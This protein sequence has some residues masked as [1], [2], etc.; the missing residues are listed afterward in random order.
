M[1][2]PV[3]MQFSDDLVKTTSMAFLYPS[4]QSGQVGQDGE[5]VVQ[6]KESRKYVSIGVRGSDSEK[7]LRKNLDIID[8]WLAVNPQ[9]TVDGEPRYLG[10]NSP[11]I[12]SFWK[13]N[14][15]QV[16][17]VETANL[18]STVSESLWGY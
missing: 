14:E 11:F 7:N 17:V 4:T 16:P 12:A 8:K 2:S 18:N 10:Y 3:E 1:T 5:V 6:D 13:Y 9:W 15:V